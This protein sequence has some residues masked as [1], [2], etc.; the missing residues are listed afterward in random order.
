MKNNAH[1]RNTAKRN[2]EK[3]KAPTDGFVIEKNVDHKM[4]TS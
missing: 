4:N 1:E 2:D 3:N